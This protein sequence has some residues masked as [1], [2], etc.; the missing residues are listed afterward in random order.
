[1]AKKPGH[2]QK[3]FVWVVKTVSYVSRETIWEK[4]CFSEK[5]FFEG[6][7]NVC[8]KSFFGHLAKKSV[9][10]GKNCNLIGEKYVLKKNIFCKLEVLSSLSFFPLK[11]F[12]ERLEA[13]FVFGKKDLFKFT[14][15]ISLGKNSIFVVVITM[16]F[17]NCNLRVQRNK[18]KRK[19]VVV[20]KR[21]GS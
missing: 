17:E 7:S 11:P 9:H 10:G 2:V 6:F 8:A 18:M 21:S 15:R 12:K 3:D 13:V 14:T 5:M 1:M 20:K 16:F 19:N 4:N